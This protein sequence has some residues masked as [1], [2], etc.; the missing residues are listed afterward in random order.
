MQEKSFTLINK[1]MNRDLSISKAGESSAY[2]N[3]NI[4]IEARDNDT[5]LSVT[6][7]KG[8]KPI[9]V[10]GS[11]IEGTLVGWN[12]LNNHIILFTHKDALTLNKLSFDF[13]DGGRWRVDAEH[14]VDVEVEVVWYEDEEQGYVHHFVIPVSGS[15]SQWIDGETGNDPIASQ[16]ELNLSDESETYAYYIDGDN[17]PESAT[18]DIIYRV[19]IS[20]TGSTATCSRLFLGNLGLDV[21]HPIESVTYFEAENIQ[22][23][24][25]LDGQHSLRFMNFMRSPMAGYQGDGDT[26][27]TGFDSNSSISSH[28]DVTIEKDNSGNARQNGVIQYFITLYNKYGQE[29][30]IAW[31]SSLIYLSPIDR[32]GSPEET[33]NNRVILRVTDLDTSYTNFRV[34]SVFRSSLNGEQVAYIVDDGIVPAS[35]GEEVVIIDDAS[36]LEVI[37]ASSI[38]FKGS[39]SAIAGTLAHKDQTLFLGNL[40]RVKIDDSALKTAIQ[41]TMFGKYVNDTFTQVPFEDGTTWESFRVGFHHSPKGVQAGIMSDVTTDIECPDTGDLYP[42]ESQLSLQSN[43][44]SSFK[45]GE[46]YRFALVFFT[47][48]GEASRAYWIGDKVNPL[49]PQFYTSG[50]KQKIRRVYAYC[51]VPRS[52]F[53]AAKECGYESMQLMMAEASYADRSIKAQG[54]LNPT[55]FNVW[56]RYNNGVYTVP[57]WITR[58]RNAGFAWKH[59][60]PVNNST[61]VTGEIECNYWETDATPTADYQILNYDTDHPTYMEEFDGMDDADYIMVIYGVGCARS[62]FK[63]IEKFLGNVTVIKAIVKQPSAVQTLETLDFSNVIWDTNDEYEYKENGVVLF[64]LKKYYSGIFTGGG[65]RK[66]SR[67]D[68]YAQVTSYVLDRLHLSTRYTVDFDTQF[69]TWCGVAQSD[70]ML[71]PDGHYWNIQ[72]TT[73]IGY[74]NNLVEPDDTLLNKPDKTAD[75]WVRNNNQVSSDINYTPAYYHKHLMFVDENTLTLDS[76]ELSEGLVSID[77]NDGLK[78][79]ILGVA[80]Q[81]STTSDYIVEASHGKLSGQNLITKDF[82]SL[83]TLPKTNAT[84]L[85][86]TSWPLWEEYGLEV[87]DEAEHPAD[88]DDYTSSDFK[89]GTNIVAY[90]LRLFGRTGTISGYDSPDGNKYSELHKKVFANLRYYYNNEYFSDYTGTSGQSALE[91]S[92]EDIRMCYDADQSAKG[93]KVEGQEQLHAGYVDSALSLPGSHKYPIVYSSSGSVGSDNPPSARKMNS[94]SIIPLTFT[95]GTHAVLSLPTVKDDTLMRYTQTI[96]PYLQS[97]VDEGGVA[98]PIYHGVYSNKNRSSISPT[99]TGAVVPWLKYD[100]TLSYPYYDYKV[101]QDAFMINSDSENFQSADTVRPYSFIGELY[102]DYDSTPLTD[103]RYGGIH[104]AEAERNTYIPIS[105]RTL[106]GMPISTTITVYGFDGDTFIQ[107]YDSLRT[108]P[109]GENENG[110]YDI[111]SAIVETHINLDGRYDNQ[112]GKKFIASTDETTFGKINPVYSQ[113]NNELQYRA[114]DDSE[115][116]NDSYKTAIT[117]SLEKKDLADIDEWTHVTLASSLLLDGDKGEC[118]ALRRFGN[119][120]IAFQDKGISEILFNSRTQISTEEGVPIEIANSGKVDGKRYITTK[121]GC[122]NKWSIVEGKAGLYFVDN[123]NKAFCAFNGEAVTNLSTKLGFESW[124]RANNSVRAWDASSASDNFIGFYDRI[125]SDV[126]LVNGDSTKDQPTIVYNEPL[127]VFTTFMSYGGVPMMTNVLDR[128]VSFKNGYLW[129]QN[130]GEYCKFFNTQYPFSMV[131]RVAPSPNDKVWTNL[132]YRADFFSNSVSSPEDPASAYGYYEPDVTFDSLRIGNEYQDT[133]AFTA[134]VAKKRFRIWRTQIPRA[135][136]DGLNNPYG[137]DRIRNPWIHLKFMKF[138]DAN[139][140]RLMQLHDITV[141]YFE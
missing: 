43:E 63:G 28:P 50:G 104:L 75:R 18:R 19:D 17:I 68:L 2:E 105:A 4:R 126:Y 14:P 62:L 1:G 138:A 55:M 33:N 120:L 131:Y 137:L 101:A 100:S 95:S 98:V 136:V 48:T 103:P 27:Y 130:E 57:S 47:K 108:K 113:S 106:I 35:N 70:P 97:T 12:V 21:N 10:T 31:V 74:T 53:N 121:Y 7:E 84:R 39:V 85:G 135:Q 125:H 129:L 139:S 42:Y 133:G 114:I 83:D 102:C 24:Y 92:L 13:D 94:K 123:I 116:T 49:Y 134:P 82:S 96:L 59:F 81:T 32:G 69:N 22:K 23:I 86:L 58:P 8:T 110:I 76:P 122:T 38:L 20:D 25:W 40:S 60:Q 9:T 29:S 117:W 46:K 30:G 91:Y 52:V 71:D 41:G 15:H 67:T 115:A 51:R 26:E 88:E 3:L 34:Y 109:L 78:L 87:D 93:L 5:L 66:G 89:W 118:S 111:S 72:D 124:F 61:E 36:H 80:W 16:C 112:R 141:K 127:G 128:F 54:L 77:R 132:E 64:V 90:W 56:E 65:N 44:I 107:R 6:N 11:F 45:G 140:N 37:D 79:R 99:H 73:T 119:S